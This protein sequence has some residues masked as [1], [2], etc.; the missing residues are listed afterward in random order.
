MTDAR[1]RRSFLASSTPRSSVLFT[2][3][4]SRLLP[5][6]VTSRLP[7]VVG[8]F[9]RSNS[10]YGLE[11]KSASRSGSSTP[12]FGGTMVLRDYSPEEMNPEDDLPETV[13]EEKSGIDWKF[14]N[15]GT[16]RFL[17]IT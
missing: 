15:Q 17:S 12:E 1:L 8:R 6:A 14:A 9:S 2:M 16:C 13:S 3:L 5:S 10:V 7:R 4:P 11:N